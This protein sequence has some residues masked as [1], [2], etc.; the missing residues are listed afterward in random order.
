MPDDAYSQFLGLPDGPRP[1]RAHVLL[2]VEPDVNDPDIIEAA[3]QRRMDQLDKYALSNDRATREQVQRLMNEVAKARV[4]LVKQA[5]KRTKKAAKVAAAEPTPVASSPVVTPRPTPQTA[6]N[7]KPAAAAEQPSAP[8]RPLFKFTFT[9]PRLSAEAWSLMGV[10]WL[11]SVVVTATGA[12]FIAGRIEPAP[13]PTTGP[14]ASNPTPD[15]ANDPDG[16]TPAVK[17]EPI[18]ETPVAEGP[19]PEPGAEPEPEPEQVPE[20]VVDFDPE[21][22]DLGAMTP[23]EIMDRVM[24]INDKGRRLTA[25]VLARN[26]LVARPQKQLELVAQGLMAFNG[27][28]QLSYSARRLSNGA[29]DFALAPRAGDDSGEY[30]NTKIKDLSAFNGLRFNS[31]YL[32]ELDALTDFSPLST[33]QAHTLRLEGCDHFKGLGA[34][35]N[36]LGLRVLSLKNI[37]INDLRSLRFDGLSE[38]SL[39]ACKQLT[40][41]NGL[42][43]KQ[44]QTLALTDTTG[45]TDFSPISQA[46]ITKR[47]DLSGTRFADLSLLANQPLSELVLDRCSN[48]SSL[49][50]LDRI[51]N[52]RTL[53]LKETR[54]LPQEV[55]QMVGTLPNVVVQESYDPSV[56]PLDIKKWDALAGI[57][58]KRLRH[59]NFVKLRD[60]L[61]PFSVAQ[62]D[63]IRKELRF[64]NNAAV[65]LRMWEGG[66]GE[67]KLRVGT[68]WRDRGVTDLSPL[69]GI[70][71][72]EFSLRYLPALEDFSFLKGSKITHLDLAG[73]AKFTDVGVLNDVEGLEH[74]V[75][76]RTSVSDLRPLL[77]KK[78]DTL[79]VEHCKNLRSLDGL[80]GMTIDRLSAAGSS[81]L[82]HINALSRVSG[83]NYLNLSETKVN[84]IATLSTQRNLE[85]LYLSNCKELSSVS[86]LGRLSK[87]KT[88]VVDGLPEVPEDEFAGLKAALR[89]TK[90]I[91][92]RPDRVAQN[93]EADPI[94]PGPEPRGLEADQTPPLSFTKIKQIESP[95][96]RQ[97][98]F[99]KLRDS[100]KPY[101]GQQAGLIREAIRAFNGERKLNIRV[102]PNKEGTAYT[103]ETSFNDREELLKGPLRNVSDIS[104]LR[105][106]SFDLLDLSGCLNVRDFSV[107]GTM[108]IKVLNLNYCMMLRDFDDINKIEGLESL[109]LSNTSIDDLDEL[110]INELDTLTIETCRK[111]SSLDGL[112]GKTIR[113]LQAG[114]NM[115]LSDYDALSQIKGMKWLDLNSTVISS[116]GPLGG[117]KLER[118]D[119]SD[120]R[121]LTE[122][123]GLADMQSLRQLDISGSSRIQDGYAEGL[124]KRIDG[125]RVIE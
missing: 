124:R 38:L 95:R 33:I 120:C 56:L 61:T 115:R 12:Y 44:I 85:H 16:S 55:A 23:R 13:A 50:G 11:M 96:D 125:L 105:G 65:D 25:Y 83:L 53:S 114:K 100:L 73:C 62:A 15:N 30:P 29:I 89:E 19:D 121:G 3:V 36:I 7:P 67:L 88:L 10:A 72:S 80:D 113:F 90:I 34:L 1:P 17:P 26:L 5:E 93:N 86:L 47:L 59:L 106:L 82:W 49:K 109:N 60:S 9:W 37:P 112:E 87:L 101:S 119:L 110:T 41:L 2:G 54:V 122:L 28:D 20:T 81:E 107:L 8:S 63:L 40:T 51:N 43:N 48:L 94:R 78:L 97:R 99:I 24:T 102:S 4:K 123:A 46:R 21:L 22:A 35:N 45:V 14:L 18:G 76:S 77:I 27:M 84:Q 66:S 68:N 111:L 57:K 79:S 31:L 116:S 71:A 58:D 6:P 75:L 42:Q 64:L 74:L 92:T 69:T 117:L 70:S 98:E 118:L 39:Q 103:F 108:K 91:Y 52:L 32:C 104:M